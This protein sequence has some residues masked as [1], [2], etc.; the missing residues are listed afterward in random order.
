M[1]LRI[2]QLA[3]EQW[4]KVA[5]TFGIIKL[6]HIQP[7]FGCLQPGQS[8]VVTFTFYGYP[9]VTSNLKAICSVEGGPDYELVLKGEA[10]VVVYEFDTK[11]L[12]YGI[13]HYF[14]LAE[15]QIVLRNKSKLTLDFIVHNC[16][17]NLYACV[18]E[19]LLTT[20]TLIPYYSN[21]YEV[22]YVGLG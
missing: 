15:G 5:K 3:P 12:N 21:F 18:L 19:R 7:M 20:L 13:V 1:T 17:D 4:C 11:L 14:E 10:D 8:E 6:F 9:H 2:K 16:I 22:S